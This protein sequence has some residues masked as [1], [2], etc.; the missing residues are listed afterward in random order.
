MYD[1]EKLQRDIWLEGRFE[2]DFAAAILV[3]DTSST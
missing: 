2:Q 1:N 3:D